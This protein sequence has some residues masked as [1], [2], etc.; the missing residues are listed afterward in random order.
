LH[1]RTIIEQYDWTLISVPLHLVHPR[2]G[3]AEY[4]LAVSK[5]ITHQL[6]LYQLLIIRRGT[7]IITAVKISLV[8]SSR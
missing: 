7:F 3:W 6:S 2:G 5:C 4:H 1:Q 8:L